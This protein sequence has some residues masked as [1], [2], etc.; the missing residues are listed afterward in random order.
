MFVCEEMAFTDLNY[1]SVV[2]NGEILTT[3]VI[4]TPVIWRGEFISISVMARWTD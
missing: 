2:L 1:S 4:D 3:S